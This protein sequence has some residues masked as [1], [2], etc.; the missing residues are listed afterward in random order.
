MTNKQEKFERALSTQNINTF[1]PVYYYLF[2]GILILISV[3]LFIPRI[4]SG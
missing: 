4:A 2:A 1:A 3:F